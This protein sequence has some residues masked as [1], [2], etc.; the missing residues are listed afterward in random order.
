MKTAYII[1]AG[2]GLGLLLPMLRN[3]QGAGFAIGS[4][5]V[6]LVDG[7]VSGTVLTVGDAV[8]VPRTDETECQRAKREGRTWDASFACPAGDFLSYVFS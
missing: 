6:D 3:P 5:A 2:A 1:A 4:A 7:V 8:G